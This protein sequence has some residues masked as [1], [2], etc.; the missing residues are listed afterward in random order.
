[1]CDQKRLR[2]ACGYRQSGQ[3]FRRL[4]EYSM[5]IKLPTEQHLDFLSL[6]GGCTAPHLSKCHIVGNHMSWLVLRFSRT[7]VKNLKKNLIVCGVE[8][9]HE[10]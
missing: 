3:S 5:T 1:M 10:V 7:R 8:Q 2:P 9:V 6:K 4:L